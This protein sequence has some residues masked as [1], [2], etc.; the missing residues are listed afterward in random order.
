MEQE[1]T[2]NGARVISIH[3]AISPVSSAVDESSELSCRLCLRIQ[4]RNKLRETQVEVEFL[5]KILDAVA[6]DITAQDKTTAVCI[7]CLRLVDVV[8]RFRVACRRADAI[9]SGEFQT[10]PAS[11]WNNEETS[12][13]LAN[14]QKVV[15]DHYTA[16]EELWQSAGLDSDSDC[17]AQDEMV[18][19]EELILEETP[20]PL[21]DFSYQSPDDESFDNHP[22]ECE[23]FPQAETL[24]NNQ[25]SSHFFCDECGVLIPNF[26]VEYHKN[27]HLGIKPYACPY[28]ECGMTFYTPKQVRVHDKH[29][30]NPELYQCEICQKTV[31]GIHSINRHMKGHEDRNPRKFPCP[32][33]KKL[34]YKSYLKDHQAVHTGVMPHE[35][36]DCG[37][38][39]GARSN[40]LKHRKKC[41][42]DSHDVVPLH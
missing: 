10:L 8:Y 3:L 7:N 38:R 39:Y 30:H 42:P 5:P 36:T 22:E 11:R 23:S 26:M 21:G 33:C 1:S 37:Q 34:F 31:K 6:I 41:H 28:T 15:K 9:L 17:M 24:E 19:K 25:K 27:K 40:L 14:C 4:P 13:V 35:C 20:S 16:M 29:V 2:E 18:F 12:Q 32:I